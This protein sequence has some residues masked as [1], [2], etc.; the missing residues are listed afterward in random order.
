MVLIYILVKENHEI[1][2]IVFFLVMF[3]LDLKFVMTLLKAVVSTCIQV[4]FIA[5]LP[6]RDKNVSMFIFAF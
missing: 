6:V 5:R 2:K 4:A 3:T 1:W